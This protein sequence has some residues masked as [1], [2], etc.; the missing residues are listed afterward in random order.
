ME[1]PSIRVGMI[2]Q[3]RKPHPCGGNRWLIYR[4]GADIGIRCQTCQRQVLLARGVF[5]QRLKSIISAP[6]DAPAPPTAPKES[7]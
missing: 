5:N 4:I 6:T 1:R 2:V 7:R 3:M